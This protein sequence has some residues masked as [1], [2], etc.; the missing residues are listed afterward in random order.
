MDIYKS[1]AFGT[2]TKEKMKSGT[3]QRGKWRCKSIQ[4]RQGRVSPLWEVSRFGG[5]ILRG[6]G[7]ETADAHQLQEDSVRAWLAA[8]VAVVVVAW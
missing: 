3:A 4:T 5:F 6:P 2:D 8:W 1:D 7:K